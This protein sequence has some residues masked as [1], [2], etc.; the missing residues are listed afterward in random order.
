MFTAN[1]CFFVVSFT[2]L[3]ERLS[4]LSAQHLISPWRRNILFINE[5]SV[6]IVRVEHVCH[7]QLVHFNL[8][9]LRSF[10][11]YLP[12]LFSY[13]LVIT[14]CYLKLAVLRTPLL[15]VVCFI[16]RVNFNECFGWWNLCSAMRYCGNCRQ[17]WLPSPTV[18]CYWGSIT[19]PLS[20][21]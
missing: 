2:G 20:N 9:M 17:L 15:S 6:Y 4:H 12:L 13:L 11:N 10:T 18:P 14:A 5:F 21:N 1:I 16:L 8:F 3:D 19:Y 7:V